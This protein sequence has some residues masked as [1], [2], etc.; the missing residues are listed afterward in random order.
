RLPDKSLSRCSPRMLD[1]TSAFAAALVP[2]V[3]QLPKPLCCGKGL[4]SGC[5][6]SSV[7]ASV[8]VAFFPAR[9]KG[10]FTWGIELHAETAMAT[11]TTEIVRFMVWLL[12]VGG[13]SK[14]VLSGKLNA[15]QA[16]LVPADD[17]SL[18]M[19]QFRAK[20]HG[21]HGTPDEV[22]VLGPV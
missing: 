3:L 4:T 21:G 7:M 9:A 17:R 20:V 15:A 5:W 8:C 22:E 14:D 18:G 2:W 19:D 6:A 10:P 1:V 13:G 12:F 11:R 16:S